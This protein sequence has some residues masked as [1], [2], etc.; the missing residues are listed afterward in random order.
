MIDSIIVYIKEFASKKRG[1]SL[2]EYGFILFMV[3]LAVTLAL[4][5]LGDKVAQLLNSVTF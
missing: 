3:A 4:K 2:V 1:Q 5:T